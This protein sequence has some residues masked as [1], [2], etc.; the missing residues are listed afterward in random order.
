MNGLNHV[1]FFCSTTVPSGVVAWTEHVGL[2]LLL[3][4]CCTCYESDFHIKWICCRFVCQTIFRLRCNVMQDRERERVR[5][6]AYVFCIFVINKFNEAAKCWQRHEKTAAFI[7]LVICYSSSN[8][9]VDGKCCTKLM[10]QSQCRINESKCFSFSLFHSSSNAHYV[11]SLDFLFMYLLF[12]SS[13]TVRN[14]I[15]CLK[16]LR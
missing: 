1:S 3:Y 7:A 16:S 13:L 6:P 5:C 12:F 14:A 9:T 11:L 4:C 8:S 2:L 10:I 15:C